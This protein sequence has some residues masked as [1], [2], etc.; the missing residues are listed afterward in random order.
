[1]LRRMGC[2]GWSVASELGEFQEAVHDVSVSWKLT[3]LRALMYCIAVR[4][5]LGFVLRDFFA[6]ERANFSFGA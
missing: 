3:V 6:G 5:W 1:M 4:Y 2:A